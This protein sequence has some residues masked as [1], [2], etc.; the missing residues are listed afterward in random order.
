MLTGHTI[1]LSH[2]KKR[3]ISACFATKLTD[4]QTAHASRMGS[5]AQSFSAL[6]Q[7]ICHT[8]LLCDKHA[9][10]LGRVFF[11]GLDLGLGGLSWFQMIAD[12]EALPAVVKFHLHK[13][14]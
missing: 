13:I 8:H 10:H 5:T 12:R 2:H 6:G 14:C 7:G 11:F 4:H 9:C 3:I 1:Q